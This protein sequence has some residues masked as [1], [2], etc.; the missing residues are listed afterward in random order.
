MDRRYFL[1]KSA[2]A[3]AGLIASQSL[4]GKIVKNGMPM[5]KNHADL[6]SNATNGVQHQA[7]EERKLG[8]ARL[9]S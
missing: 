3:G 4:L 9:H 1:K 2:L 7:F 5:S 8:N 6:D